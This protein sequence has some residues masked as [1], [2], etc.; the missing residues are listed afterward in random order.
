MGTTM[1]WVAMET[2]PEL[3]DK[4][5]LM[6]GLAPVASVARM[7]SPIKFLAP[8]ANRLETLFHFL[9]TD[10]F[11]PS[12]H[13]E[14]LFQKYVCDEG[15]RGLAFCENILFLLSG[16]D[17]ANF[18]AAELPLITA[19][20]PAGTS[21]YTPIHYLQ[22]YLAVGAQ[23]FQRMDWGPDGNMAAYGTP[24]PPAYNLT[25]VAAPVV[26]FF[27]DNDW[28]A[29]PQDVTWL[30]KQLVNLKGFYRVDFEQFNHLDFLW[31]LN[32]NRLL[33]D[34]LLDLLP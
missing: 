14:R 24:T 26:L 3:N 33:Y 2:R 18:N 28:L 4:I 10:A 5:E 20:T 32:V 11:L 29:T 9:G 31:A 8:F 25:A 6:V 12:S 13:L 21:T 30:A 1:F 19:H 34:R 7:K 15:R 22:E 23:R 27:G 16:S 17:P